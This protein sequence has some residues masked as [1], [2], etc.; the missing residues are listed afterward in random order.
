MADAEERVVLAGRDAIGLW[1]QSRV[2]LNT[3]VEENPVADIDFSEAGFSKY[4][5]VP[6]DGF[7]FPTGKKDFLEIVFGNGNVSFD[8]PTL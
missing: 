3:W 2:A 1:R 5:S 6:F 4:G 7:H 8:S